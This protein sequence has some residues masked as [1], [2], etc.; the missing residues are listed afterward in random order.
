MTARDARTLDDLLR[1][2]VAAH[3]RR[4]AVVEER[5]VTY[6]ELFASAQ[7]VARLLR[8]RGARPGD[9]VGLSL[10]RSAASVAAVWG[11]VLGGT[12][13]LPLDPS[14]PAERLAALLREAR[15][16]FVLNEADL[17]AARPSGG[18]ARAARVSPGDLAYVLYTSGSTGR[19]KGVSLTHRNALAF[20]NWARRAV[21]L[22][23]RDRVAHMA[24]LWFDL[25]VYEIF[26]AAAAGA[27]VCPV[28]EAVKLFPR[29]LSTYLRHRGVTTLYAVPSTLTALAVRGSLRAGFPRLRR[30]LFAGEVFPA[31]Y[32]SAWRRRLPH[33][34]FYNLYGPTETNVCAFHRVAGRTDPH[35][36]PPPIG[37][38]ASGARLLSVDGELWVSGPS[39]MRGYLRRP[40][41]TR[42][43][44]V[45]RGGRTYYRTGDLVTREEGGVFRW[46]GRRDRQIKSRGYR[47]EPAEIERWLAAHPAV[48]E[49]AIVAVPDPELTN[50][51]EAWVASARRGPAFARA[52]TDHCARRLPAYML[53]TRF[54]FRTS[55][56]R[57]STGKLDRTALGPERS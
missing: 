26:N 55:L 22:S 13:Y 4:A 39:V 30:V 14:A 7:G 47:I 19:P 8:E 57:T 3:P 11:A 25:S 17:A 54:H 36:P 33:A 28:P 50:R 20:I 21:P 10:R 51:V 52:L 27:A 31:R 1:R 41:E 2:A 23:S 32:F 29:A 40:R 6:R 38:A 18:G 53:P 15:P 12:P 49:A 24:P 35:G 34:A 5:A 56:P 42:A 9:L 48:R 44:L 45:R 43:A 46:L 16:K 37:R